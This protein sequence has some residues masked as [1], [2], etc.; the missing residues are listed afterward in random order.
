MHRCVEAV[1]KPLTA[2]ERPPNLLVGVWHTKDHPPANGVGGR[3][4]SQ[5]CLVWGWPFVGA[6]AGPY[7][8][9]VA[10]FDDDPT[11]TQS[12]AGV[13]VALDLSREHLLGLLRDRR[14]TSLYLSTN[15]RSLPAAA[16]QSLVARLASQVVAAWPDVQLVLRGD[17]TLRGHLLPEYLGAA[18]EGR[19]PL[20]LVPA[21]PEAGRVT[22]G[23][24]HYLARG[25]REVPLDQTEYSRDGD[26]GFTTSDL[27]RW[28]EE[29]S[30]GLFA[31]SRALLISLERL[32]A[33]GA[34][35]IE[36]TLRAA[37]EPG[38]PVVCV[39]DAADESDL[40]QIRLGLSLA[41]AAGVRAVLRCAPPLA[42]LVAGRRARSLVA[43]PSS[44]RLL[45]LA[46]S[47]VPLSTA[48][49]VEVERRYPGSGVCVELDRLLEAPAEE[50]R[51]LAREVEA[52]WRSTPR[53]VVF[54]PR[55]PPAGGVLADGL[56]RRVAEGLARVLHYLDEP[57]D[58]V[59][60]KGGITA[61]VVAQVGLGGRTAWVVGP[62]A[63]GLSLWQVPD[64]FAEP[65]ARSTPCV[66]FP[67]NVG[68][69]H[70]LAELM[71]RASA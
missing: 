29:R 9:G 12:A 63:A 27:A 58:L 24:H 61:A 52:R 45:V 54:T 3:G 26:F 23:G 37:E 25:D 47:Y 36:K 20:L 56:G 21:M 62:P 57:P 4:R 32:H 7:D 11:G 33:E 59:V 68:G 67:G 28:A 69:P 49:L 22:R 60:A 48:Q 39:A 16:T 43:V 8:G 70:A 53:A 6:D 18:G 2:R 17:S 65:A 30:A 50:G 31:A 38:A 40:E 46:G 34:A 15:A 19:P 64:P 41:R 10:V 44:Q 71:A 5:A 14:P 1:I 13:S 35:A 51:R 66:V 55:R 42:A